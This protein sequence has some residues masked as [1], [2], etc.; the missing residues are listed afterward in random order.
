VWRINDVAPG[1]RGD[2]DD[3]AYLGCYADRNS[4]RVLSRAVDGRRDAGDCRAWCQGRDYEY[5]GR[6]WRGQCFCGNREDY[7]RHESA[8][9]CDCCG[10][11]VGSHK[12]CMW[13]S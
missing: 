6:E 1:C 12:I 5:F 9:D 11:N 3:T 13:R 8:K 4:H 10:R 2:Y 7:H